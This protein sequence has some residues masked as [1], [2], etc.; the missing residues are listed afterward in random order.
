MGAWMCPLCGHGRFISLLNRSRM[1]DRQGC[2]YTERVGDLT[3][4]RERKAHRARQR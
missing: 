2:G 4:G 1:C 3:G